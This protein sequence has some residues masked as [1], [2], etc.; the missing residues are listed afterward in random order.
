M[1]KTKDYIY[2]ENS[3]VLSVPLCGLEDVV[4]LSSV[5]AEN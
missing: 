5:G 4:S 2:H 1:T 3:F